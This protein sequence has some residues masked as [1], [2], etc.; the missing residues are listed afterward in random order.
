MSWSNHWIFLVT[1]L[2]LITAFT[3]SVFVHSPP[4]CGRRRRRQSHC[5]TAAATYNFAV[6]VSGFA[7]GAPPLD[8]DFIAEEE[9]E[10]AKSLRVSTSTLAAIRPWTVGSQNNITSTLPA[11][12]TTMA[13]YSGSVAGAGL[14]WLGAVSDFS[15]RGGYNTSKHSYSLNGGSTWSQHFMPTHPTSKLLLTR[16][17]LQWQANSDPVA[18]FGPSG[19]A[20]YLANLYLNAANKAN[21]LYVA[22]GT[23]PTTSGPDV[24]SASQIYPVAVNSSPTSTLFEDKPWLTADPTTASQLYIVWTRF[25]FATGTDFILFATSTNSG[26][27]WSTPIQ[28]SPFN[29]NGGV[30]GAQVAVDGSGNVW[31]VWT[32]FFAN[33]LRR[34]YASRSNNRGVSFANVGFPVTPYFAKPSFSSRYRKEA[35]AALAVE[36]ASRT[37]HIAYPASNAQGFS[38]ILYVR[39]VNGGTTFTSPVNLVNTTSGNQFMPAISADSSVSGRVQVVWYDSRNNRLRGNRQ[40]DVYAALSTT[41]GAT[42]GT[43][44]RVTP[45]STDVGSSSFVGDYCGVS[46]QGGL[47]LPAWAFF[48]TPLRTASLV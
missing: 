11:A 39:S 21:G 10:G 46:S 35:F 45:S 30:Q 16:D 1:L 8:E 14:L 3:I 33:G 15:Q 29:Q 27:T 2:V 38:K 24:W 42:W 32:V 13:S 25:N 28:V 18:C 31:V 20:V 43:N 9:M 48:V 26:T 19:R 17:N 12:E 34:L 4:K 37:V 22:A 44:V 40:L 5:S 47:S 41:A 7:G 36:R 23:L 6:D